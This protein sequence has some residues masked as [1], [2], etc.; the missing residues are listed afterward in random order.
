MVPP[1]QPKR[2]PLGLAYIVE[3]L[4]AGGFVVKVF[5]FNLELYRSADEKERIFW[6]IYNI[7]FM[8]ISEIANKMFSVFKDD[9]D[10]FVERILSFDTKFI[11]F[12]VNIAS[13]G[14]AGKIATQIKKKNRDKVIIFGGTACF[15]ENDRQCIFPEDIAAVDVIV[16]GEGE[17]VLAEMLD[18]KPLNYEG[19]EGVLYKKEDFFRPAKPHFTDNLDKLPFP[20]YL[21]FDLDAYMERQISIVISRGCIGRCAFCID[22]LMCGAYRYRSAD[23]VFE[24]IKYHLTVNK[25]NDFGFNDLICN[26]NLKQLEEICDLVI[27]NGFK[28]IWGSY[29]M[30]R[31][32]MDESLLDKMHQAGCVF[33]CYGLESGCNRTLKRM[34]KFYSAED[35]Q[36]LIRATHNARI[37]TAVNIILG[38]PGETEEDF[39]QTLSFIKDNKDYL[40]Q[41]TN[42]S[43]FVIMPPSRLGSN[44]AAYGVKVP[45]S[46]AL[47]SYIDENGLE[48]I[49]RVNR[50][51]KTIFHVFRL[52]IQDIIINQ[53]NLKRD[54]LKDEV[55]LILLSPARIDTPSPKIASLLSS[56]REKNLNPV[57]YDFNIKLYNSVD[58]DLKYLW[59]YRYW[60]LW[61]SPPKI[62]NISDS[63][64]NTIFSTANEILSLRTDV[65]Y[66][67]V[68]VENFYF[69]IFIAS[70]LKKWA[71]YILIIFGGQ[72]FED[73]NILE[74]IP[75][76]TVDIFINRNAAGILQQ[77]LEKSYKNLDAIPG[78]IICKNGAYQQPQKGQCG[79]DSN[80]SDEKFKFSFE[81]FDLSQYE[82]LRLPIIA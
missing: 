60:H 28:I 65:F 32:G 29:A 27:D 40:H 5:D 77:I 79:T 21:E 52:G 62:F 31:K 80:V 67:H 30:I 74:L 55:A 20:K 4:K 69:S 11:G 9:I 2:P 70:I 13:I 82:N 16:A 37:Q 36:A 42:I 46:G 26:G 50:I 72:I 18:R 41:V 45:L 14:L 6:E 61:N 15:W 33:L 71:P 43:G 58:A 38:F 75:I 63:L 78:A 51:R 76:N 54:T 24:E 19:I 25:I 48:I 66:F 7:N 23:K 22:H 64:S 17:E 8:T 1:W 12:S 44:L 34:N 68:D 3:Y 49:G 10:A 56:L 35:A 73:A 57:I 47:D 81:G 53:P 39:N 59:E